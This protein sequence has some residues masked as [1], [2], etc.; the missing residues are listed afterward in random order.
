MLA[1]L[2]LGNWTIELPF[3]LCDIKLNAYVYKINSLMQSL[4]MNIHVLNKTS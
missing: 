2:N 3:H 1:N 4:E